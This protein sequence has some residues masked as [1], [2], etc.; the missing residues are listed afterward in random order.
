MGVCKCNRLDDKAAT[1]IKEHTERNR[2]TERRVTSV[3]G[4]KER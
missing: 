1:E 3:H 4:L 2:E